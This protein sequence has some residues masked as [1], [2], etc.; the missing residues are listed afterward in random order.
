M[1]DLSA[2][3]ASLEASP[4]AWRAEPRLLEQARFRLGE[5]ERDE[6]LALARRLGDRPADSICPDEARLPRTGALLRQ[7]SACVS[8]GPGFAILEGFPV[9]ALSPGTD[10]RAAEVAFWASI[11]TVGTPDR[12]DLAGK[13]LHHVCRSRPASDL[14]T[15][16]DARAYETDIEI[17]FHGDG[18]DALFFLC[19]NQGKS[20]G[21]SRLVSAERAFLDVLDRDA[22][23]AAALME[24]FHFDA[25]S[26]RADGAATQRAPIAAVHEGRVSFL[27]KRG[28]IE[29]AQRFA[30]IPRL[31]RIQI[32][33]M[34]AFDA[35]L[36]DPRNVLAFRLA[37]GQILSANNYAIL[38]AR[39]AFEDHEAPE[40]RRLFLRIWAT[41]TEG[42]PVADA[43]ADTREFSQSWAR[44]NGASIRQPAP[45]SVC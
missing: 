4:R 40:R 11:L 30:E 34:D 16:A 32:A 31:S 7:V 3:K 25:R 5:P 15:T 22:S 39:T 41:L 42:P 27:Y 8:N 13:R 38:H 33:A 14:V 36:N 18:S 26:Q 24:P 17:G 45:G 19:V 23:L 10:R 43:F 12:Q 21:E 37:P 9:R 6:I 20:G 28:Y 35:A 44:K 2:I 1:Q 29:S